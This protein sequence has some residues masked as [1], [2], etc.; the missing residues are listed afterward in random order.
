MFTEYP[1]VIEIAKKPGATWGT[2]EDYHLAL[3]TS[4]PLAVIL[5][6]AADGAPSRLEPIVSNF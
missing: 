3:G 2:M 6:V 1:E 4:T 5:F